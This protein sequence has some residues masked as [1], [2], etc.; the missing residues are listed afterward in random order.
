MVVNIETE[1]AVRLFYKKNRYGKGDLARLNKAFIKIVNKVLLSSLEF[2]SRLLVEG[3]IAKG[4]FFIWL[5][6]NLIV[7]RS[8]RREYVGC[9]LREYVFKFLVLVG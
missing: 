5:N 2:I 8:V 9:C 3:A 1:S 4:I 6:L 7:I